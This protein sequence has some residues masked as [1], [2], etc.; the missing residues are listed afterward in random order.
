MTIEKS[1]A[2]SPETIQIAGAGPAG[3]AA[4]ITL[5]RGGRKVVVHEAANEVGHRFGRDLQGLENWSTHQDV[6]DWMQEQG[7][8]TAFSHLPCRHGAAFDA[9]GEC[10]QIGSADTLFYMVERGPGEGS[11]DWALAKKAREEGVE[12]R[13][14]SR[15]KSMEGPGILAMGPR[16]AD[17][18]AVGY[19]FDTSMENGFWVILDNNL[20]PKG[21]SY[22]LVLE[23]RG[24]VKSCM[25]RDFKNE[26]IYVERTVDAFKRL[27]NADMRN[28][29]HHG[30][31]GNLYLPNRAVS[32]IHPVVGEQAG[33]QDCLWGFGMR[34]AMH[35]GILAAQCLL[36]GKDFEAVWRQHYGA[37]QRR[38]IVNRMYYS[39]L[40]NRGY[41]WAL[42]LNRGRR[43]EVEQLLH[44]LYNPSII[45]KL[46][47]P[48][49]RLWVRSRR[50]DES[51][52]HENCAC[53]WC[54]HGGH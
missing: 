18:I 22:L 11:L 19:H 5:A 39:L 42:K 10:Y 45:G 25:F 49:A 37:L 33:F 24:T 38:S 23:G 44:R 3:L 27:L 8:S 34:Y 32:G 13:F 16:T 51:C 30:G 31:A 48:W 15:L 43:I 17:A 41:R 12:I 6:L 47:Y 21:Y 52:N 36:N 14:N 50:D 20:A 46:L 9:W 35:S 7:L 54:R 2:A 53:T 28:M 26:S 40:G 29:K 4:A 1:V